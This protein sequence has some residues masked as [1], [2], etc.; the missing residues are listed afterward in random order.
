[1]ESATVAVIDHY[2]RD[3]KLKKQ[4]LADSI[5]Q[6]RMQVSQQYKIEALR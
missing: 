3:E 1:M 4:L 2:G 6:R 5:E